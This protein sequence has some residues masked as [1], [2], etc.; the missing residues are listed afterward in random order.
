MIVPADCIN[1]Q[2]AN[3]RNATPLEVFESVRYVLGDIELDPA[4]DH[5]INIEVKAKRIY[6]I[7]DDGFSKKW[8]AKTLWLNPPGKTWIDCDEKCGG[9]LI[10]ASKWFH[11]LHSH[12]IAGEVENAIALVYRA[13]SIGSLG[14][15]ILQN[16]ICLTT[17]GAISKTINGSGRFSFDLIAEDGRKSSLRNTQSS[18]FLLF[19]NSSKMLVKFNQEFKKYGAIKI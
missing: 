10:T 16:P 9:R 1:N 19:S 7:E 6:T 18:M 15:E 12:W 2:S 11:K 5:T 13:G 3:G 17:S 14:M 4:S 8:V